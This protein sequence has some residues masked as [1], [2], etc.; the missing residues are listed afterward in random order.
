MAFERMT[1]PHCGGAFPHF[2]S[3]RLSPF[4][5]LECGRCGAGVK[6]KG[7]LVPLALAVVGILA[8]GY[9]QS[10]VSLTSV[11]KI[12]LLLAI[13]GVVLVIDE[14]TVQLEVVAEPARDR[15]G[16]D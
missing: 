3:M 4:R 16:K 6:R 13:V 10:V 14:S 15:Q 2:S 5:P 12:L 9:V 1:C 8:F 11:G 7:K